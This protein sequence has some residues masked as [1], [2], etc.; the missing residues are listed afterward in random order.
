MLIVRFVEAIF[1]CSTGRNATQLSSSHLPQTILIC[2]GIPFGHSNG[3]VTIF[4]GAADQ[5]FIRSIVIW[6]WTGDT[7]FDIKLWYFIFI[8]MHVL[9]AIDNGDERFIAHTLT[10][11][12]VHASKHHN[13]GMFH[14]NGYYE[15]VITNF[16]VNTSE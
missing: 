14:G 4:T 7:N 16:R 11:T 10:H 3:T 8:F 1:V 6:T 5:N 12:H 2:T 15:K 13:F 9:C